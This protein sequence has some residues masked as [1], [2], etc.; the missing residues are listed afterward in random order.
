MAQGRKVD[1]KTRN[2][3]FKA[4]IEGWSVADIARTERLNYSTVYQL[5]KK[6]KP[7]RP[8]GGWNNRTERHQD[9]LPEPKTEADLSPEARRALTDI[10]YFARRFFGALLLPW[11]LEATEKIVEWYD[12]DQEEFVCVNAPP[13]SGKSFFFT[14]I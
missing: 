8:G 1:P 5:L 2:R 4:K 12:N 14:R 11:Q 13:G 10:V 7:S 6:N 3:I 9:Q